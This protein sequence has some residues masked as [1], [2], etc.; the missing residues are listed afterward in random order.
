MAPTD[1]GDWVYSDSPGIW[2]VYRVITGVE[3]IRGSLLE[4]KR[5]R[6][7]GFV[8]SK[9]LLDGTWKP[10]FRNEVASAD[11]IRPLSSDDRQRLDEFLANN[12]QVK[13]Q[14]EAFKPTAIDLR[15]NL[16]LDIP[17]SVAKEPVLQLIQEV[18]ADIADGLTNDKILERMAATTLAGFA[19]KTIRNA[20][21]Q[22]V[23]K[24]HELH[25]NEY[26]FREVQLLMA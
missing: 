22:F 6:R 26:V 3:K 1:V 2:Q 24:D 7:G 9:R 25:D 11:L 17:A 15:L 19:P 13:Q 23:C 4:R 18:F 16:S 14:F 10:A 21:L 8:F 5:S 12:S 20:T